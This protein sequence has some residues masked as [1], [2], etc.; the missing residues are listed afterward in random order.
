MAK[1]KG[2]GEM[3]DGERQLIASRLVD[4]GLLPYYGGVLDPAALENLTER[5]REVFGEFFFEECVAADFTAPRLA[6]R[7]DLLSA[8]RFDQM[9][10]W[11][12][13]RKIQSERR[14]RAHTASANCLCRTMYC[15]QSRSI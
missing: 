2:A 11:P 4:K 15:G 3:T 14:A 13:D 12:L 8:G 10:S 1:K 7:R 9:E 5:E 6:C